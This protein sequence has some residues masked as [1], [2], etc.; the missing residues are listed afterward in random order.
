MLCSSSARWP[1]SRLLSRLLGALRSRP[2]L[3]VSALT[4]GVAVSSLGCAAA[5]PVVAPPTPA[6]IPVLEAQIER[7]PQRFDLLFRLGVAYREAGRFQDARVVLDRA[8]ILDPGNSAILFHQGLTEE[9]REAWGE[10][11][12]HYDEF[13]AAAPD[14]ELARRVRGRLPHLRRR[15]LAADVRAAVQQ[16]GQLAQTEPDSRTLA[17][18]P[19]R[20]E[21]P[22]PAFEP[23]G[24]AMAELTVSDVARVGRVTV[25]ERLR[26]QLLLDELALAGRGQVDPATAARSGRMLGAGRIAQ[27]RLAGG[28]D[29]LE[30]LGAVVSVG[31]PGM[32]AAME[33]AETLERFYDLQR[34]WVLALHEAMGV[35][36]TDAER[37][38]IWERPFRGLSSLLLLGRGLEAEDRGDFALALRLFREATELEPGFE[39]AGAGVERS[40]AL[41]EGEFTDVDALASLG[42]TVL[43]PPA[44][45]LPGLPNAWLEVEGLIPNVESRSPAA[46]LLGTEGLGD[47]RAI[48]EILIRVPGG[49]R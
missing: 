4:V 43:P 32:P 28:G 33:D 40:E 30:L 26:V 22:D 20:Y 25:L 37:D 3:R 13:L 14:S 48:L 12:R 24:R 6:E 9:G 19:F 7:G 46:E 41:I 36:L 11:L 38:R 49:D 18:F 21:G 2:R 10:A 44:A 47:A 15:Q 31:D 27:G 23:L 5:R 42:G 39:E 16:E 35:Q 45:D 29:R 34:R 1:L 8:R 17:V